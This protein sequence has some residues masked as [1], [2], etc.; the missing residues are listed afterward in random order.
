MSLDASLDISDLLWLSINQ[1]SPRSLPSRISAQGL[2][3][4]LFRNHVMLSLYACPYPLV[5]CSWLGR[6]LIESHDGLRSP[7]MFFNIVDSSDFRHSFSVTFLAL[8]K[9]RLKLML[10]IHCCLLCLVPQVF[11]AHD[12][13][14]TVHANDQRIWRFRHTI[15]CLTCIERIKILCRLS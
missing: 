2:Q 5:S 3:K 13:S 6:F 11:L 8:R 7:Y 9:S 10:L 15:R 4:C 1:H 14:L 12:D